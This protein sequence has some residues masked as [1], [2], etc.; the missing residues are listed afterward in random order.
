RPADGERP[1]DVWRAPDTDGAPDLGRAA[2]TARRVRKRPTR[3]IR[4]LSPAT[5]LLVL[6]SFVVLPFA[7]VSCGLPDGYGRAKPSGST[8]Y[9]G[10]SLALGGI[11]DVPRDHLRPRA[12]RRNDRL[13]PQPLV[14]LALLGVVA[15]TVTSIVLR[16]PRR[17]WIT[18]A[19]LAAGA[20]LSL[21]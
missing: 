5:F 14:L 20:A 9:P 3:H 15:G 12:E 19:L 8:R 18:V 13:P 4:W 6:L 7:T 21:T 10:L 1:P 11:P 16:L 2:P 17:R